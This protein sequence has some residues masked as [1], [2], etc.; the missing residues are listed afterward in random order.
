MD[1]VFHGYK[2]MN[3]HQGAVHIIGFILCTG[4]EGRSIENETEHLLSAAYACFLVIFIFQ[5]SVSFS[6]FGH[7]VW[8]SQTFY[9]SWVIWL[10]LGDRHALLLRNYQ[11]IVTTKQV[12]KSHNFRIVDD[13]IFAQPY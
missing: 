5:P 8:G 10:S 2:M 11:N 4:A 9:Q 1:F 6:F 13:L 7:C 12:K 3:S